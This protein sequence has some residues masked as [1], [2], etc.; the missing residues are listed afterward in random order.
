MSCQCSD[1]GWRSLSNSGVSGAV[2]LRGFTFCGCQMD[3]SVHWGLCRTCVEKGGSWSSSING[4]FQI[5]GEKFY[6]V[7]IEVFFVVQ[8]VL[9]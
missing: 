3:F 4:I 8:D 5:S 2:L 6:S 7:L 9:L 1:Q